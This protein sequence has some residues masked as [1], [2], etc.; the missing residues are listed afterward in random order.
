MPR[1]PPK[2]RRFVKG[3]V[4]NPLGAGAHNKELRQV[5]QLTQLEI[6]EVGGFILN[7]NLDALKEVRANPKS[8]VFKVWICSVAI[9]A[10]NKGDAHSLNILLDRIV[11]KVKDTTQMTVNIHKDVEGM[12]EAEAQELIKSAQQKL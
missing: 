3:Q 10:I 5:K 4:A 8:S 7:N 9:T 1:I 6:A 11:G 12:T 2:G